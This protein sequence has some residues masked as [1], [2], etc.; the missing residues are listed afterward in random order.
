MQSEEYSIVNMLDYSIGLDAAIKF[1]HAKWGNDKNYIFFADAIRHSS[2]AETGLPRFYL[3]LKQNEMVGCCGLV[4]NDFISR[5][6][7]YPWMAG[8]YVI[9]SERGQHLGNFMMRHAEAEAKIAGHSTL[10]LTTDHDGYYEKYGWERMEDG[11]ELSG[12]PT[13]IYRKLL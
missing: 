7:L 1:Y 5:H 3:L 9:K 6:D 2:K 8:I 10:Y 11:F 13:R 12:K 4:T